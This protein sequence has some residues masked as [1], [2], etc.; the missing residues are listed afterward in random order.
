[1]LSASAWGWLV[2]GEELKAH[3]AKVK[4][5]GGPRLAEEER[6]EYLFVRWARLL[7]MLAESERKDREAEKDGQ[8]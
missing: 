8:S 4:A 5:Q 1:M 3:M 6:T 2:T 7:G